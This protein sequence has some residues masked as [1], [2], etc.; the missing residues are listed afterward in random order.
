MLTVLKNI[1]KK[2]RIIKLFFLNISI[3]ILIIFPF[4]NQQIVLIHDIQ[5]IKQLMIFSI[6]KGVRYFHHQGFI[7]EIIIEIK[8]IFIKFFSEFTRKN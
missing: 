8:H 7:Q 5:M 6:K 3:F 1:K 4:W 2:K